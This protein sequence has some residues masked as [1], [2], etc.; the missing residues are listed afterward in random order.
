MCSAGSRDFF[1]RTPP[2]PELAKL[3]NSNLSSSS[4]SA[5][6]AAA[7]TRVGVDENDT[8]IAHPLP[9]RAT[10]FEVDVTFAMPDWKKVGWD[11]GVQLFWSDGDEELTRVGIRDGSWMRGVDLWVS[12]PIGD[13]LLQMFAPEF[14]IRA[15]QL[16][17]NWSLTRSSKSSTV[18]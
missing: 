2:L 12:L 11:V 15:Q 7:L 6:I 16:S 9:L 8:V 14:K 17:S 4:S 18:S 10:S 3:R 13:Q 1:L 5:S